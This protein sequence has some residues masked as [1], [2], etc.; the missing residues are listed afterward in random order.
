MKDLCQLAV[1]LPICLAWFGP[2][3]TFPVLAEP[4]QQVLFLEL[5][6]LEDTGSACRLSF[7]LRNATGTDLEST[8]YELVLFSTDGVIDHMSV[9]DFGA[10]PADKT[11]VR[12]F[13]L[14]SV[15][16]SNAGRL[17]VNG[18]SGC[19]DPA[20]AGHCQASLTLSSRT[21]LALTQ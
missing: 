8:A 5:N 11:V 12:Q 13:E 2:G 10:L 20:Q 6:K 1:G 3:L 21:D 16:C 9:F 4:A 18:P 17:L 19:A 14:G 15:A 7:V